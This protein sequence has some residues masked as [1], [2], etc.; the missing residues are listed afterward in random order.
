MENNYP[1]PPSFERAKELNDYHWD[2]SKPNDPDIIFK[3]KFRGNWQE[4][5][6]LYQPL[7]ME[8]DLSIESAQ[9]SWKEW[10]KLGYDAK[11]WSRKMAVD[12]ITMPK[13]YKC[14]EQIKWDPAY[15]SQ[16]WLTEQ[17]PMQHLPLHMDYLGSVKIDPKVATEKGWRMLVFLTDW[18]PGEFMVWGTETISHWKAGWV[19]AW[20]AYKYPHG[21]A[22]VSYHSGFRLK[23]AGIMSDT[24]KEW[25]ASD[26]IID[27]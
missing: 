27:I 8:V 26:N 25:L 4:E 6:K 10:L 24:L 3:Q 18:W 21:T 15:P 22:N 11:S 13:I 2:L 19:L 12:S 7:E 16:C 1:I 23:T 17:K 20:P 14:C 5:V 9:Q